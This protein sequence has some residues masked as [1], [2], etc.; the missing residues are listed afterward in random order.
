MDTTNQDPDDLLMELDIPESSDCV[1]H[2]SEF[3][4]M[5]PDN[6]G[7]I[8]YV[9]FVSE[10]GP[11]EVEDIDIPESENVAYIEDSFEIRD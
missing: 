9:E 5:L 1:Y 2:C 8:I 4:E 7:F 11:E 6:S 10:L 3:E